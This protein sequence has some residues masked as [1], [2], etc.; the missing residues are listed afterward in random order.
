MDKPNILMIIS[1]DT[2]RYLGAYDHNVETP[3]LNELAENG[4]RF[5]NY[6]CSQ[7]QCSPSRGSILTGMY[8]HNHGMLGLAHMGHSMNKDVDTIPSEMNKA[9]YDTYLFGFFHESIDGQLDGEKL[10]YQHVVEVPG[11]AAK[12]VTDKVEAFLEERSKSSNHSPFYASVGFE[13]THRPFDDFE[14]VP[15]ESVEV[16][17]YLPDTK[18]V[19]ED[20]AYFYGSIK[21]LDRN[22]GRIKKSLEEN[23]LA[24][25]TLLIYTT[26]HGIAFPRA[27]GTLFDAGLETALIMRLPKGMNN[28]GRVHDELLCNIDLLPT[29]VEIAGG[30]IPEGI[31]GASFLPLLKEDSFDGRESFFCELSWHDRYHPMRGIRTTKYKYIRNFEDGPKVYLPFDIHES[32]SGQDVREGYYVSNSEEELY[33][34]EKD[35]LEEHNLADDEN[36]KQVLLD[37]RSKVEKWMKDSNDPLLEGPI[38]G[39]EATEWKEEIEL[40]NVYKGSKE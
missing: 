12:N 2:G 1:H 28:G 27:K 23:G 4:V 10:G 20:L 6:F 8:G 31:D 34:L 35:P 25:N 33:D 21:E 17:P 36:Y 11:N 38:P 15:L 22:V 26:D 37:L 13:E 18:K 39:V 16:P 40:G 3:E 9:G 19:R 30:N 5:D 29:L 24:D 14:P 32:L 7:P